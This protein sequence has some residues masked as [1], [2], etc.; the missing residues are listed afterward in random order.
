MIPPKE[1]NT[2]AMDSSKKKINKL[3]KNKNKKNDAEKT[4]KNTRK[5]S[6]DN[7]VESG[8]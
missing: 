4:Q 6:I 8:K 1:Q 7:S 5:Y 2:V 3:P